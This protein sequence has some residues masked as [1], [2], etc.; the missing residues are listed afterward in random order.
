V[1][2]NVIK[3]GAKWKEEGSMGIVGFWG[4]QPFDEVFQD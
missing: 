2:N 1:E 4:D 3:K